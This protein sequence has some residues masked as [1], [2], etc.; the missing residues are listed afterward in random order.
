MVRTCLDAGVDP[1]ARDGNGWT[2]LHYAAGAGQTE[3][4][5][6]LIAKGA[7]P[8]ARKENGAAP[9]HRA[10]QEGQT[11]ASAA[12]LEAGVDPNARGEKG[13]TP[14]HL[15]AQEGR[16]DA[17]AALL[18]A[19]A[20]L[21]ARDKWDQIPFDLIPADSPLVGTS[22]YWRLAHGHGDSF[23]RWRQRRLKAMGRVAAILHAGTLA[24]FPDGL[25]RGPVTLGKNRGAPLE[26]YTD[27]HRKQA[28]RLI[29]LG[30]WLLER[31]QSDPEIAGL[32]ADELDAFLREDRNLARNRVLLADLLDGTAPDAA[33]KGAL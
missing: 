30:T 4:I 24:P 13:Y 15:A 18:E 3:A 14:L 6:A 23:L 19:G 22:A 33:T 21:K 12:L 1:N 17:I 8:N 11:K 31:W 32:V 5:A 29:L 7:D 10:A 27:E 9:L 26:R 2:P 25:F 28:Q 20:D 16:T